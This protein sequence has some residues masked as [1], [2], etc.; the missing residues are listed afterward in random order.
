MLTRKGLL[1]AFA[2]LAVTGIVLTAFGQKLATEDE[3]YAKGR[4]S[5][6]EK[7]YRPAATAFEELLKRFPNTKHT[8]K[9]TFAM[10]PGQN[11]SELCL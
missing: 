5:F 2:I 8:R 9:A 10:E 3:L 7:S 1:K 4:K 11:H 6:L